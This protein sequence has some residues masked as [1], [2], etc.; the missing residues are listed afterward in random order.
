M[1]LFAGYGSDDSGDSSNGDARPLEGVRTHTESNDSSNAVDAM[2]VDTNQNADASH[3]QLSSSANHRKRPLDINEEP[4][5]T[6]ATS[7][8]LPIPRTEAGGLAMWSKDYVTVK[9]TA[10]VCARRVQSTNDNNVQRQQQLQS[11]PLHVSLI[12]VPPTFSSLQAIVDAMGVSQPRQVLGSMIPYQ[13]GQFEPWEHQ[14]IQ[15][16]EPSFT[17]I[18]TPSNT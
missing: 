15:S 12:R 7:M 2:L 10:F 3:S 8:Q 17:I 13:S 16:N 1:D 5:S 9:Q 6:L 4:S 11:T 14:W 18:Q